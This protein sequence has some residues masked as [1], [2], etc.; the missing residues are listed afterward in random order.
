MQKNNRFFK[1]IIIKKKKWKKKENRK[2]K[3]ITP[4]NCKSP[5]QRQMFITTVK[6]VTEE[7]TKKLKSLIR[8]HSDNKI[9][10]YNRG[11][12]RGGNP[13]ES[14]GQVKTQE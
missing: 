4:Q 6:N 11:G 2:K 5:T 10:N 7:K 3:S 9:D 14:T 8:F 13:K 1:I 12:K